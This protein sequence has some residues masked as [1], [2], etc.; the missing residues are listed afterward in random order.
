MIRFVQFLLCTRGLPLVINVIGTGKGSYLVSGER[1]CFLSY[2]WR[3]DLQQNRDRQSKMSSDQH[4]L[5]R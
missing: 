4:Q 1:G 2:S 5:V 3:L